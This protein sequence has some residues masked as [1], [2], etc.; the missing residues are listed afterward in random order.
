MLEKFRIPALM[1]CFSLV[2]SC[3]DQSDTDEEQPGNQIDMPD[4]SVI[5][6]SPSQSGDTARSNRDTNSG[7]TIDKDPVN[8]GE[9]ID[10]MSSQR[11]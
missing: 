5:P 2:L 10:T 9:I 11:R 7:T 3:N 6:D 8:K 1:I 4:P